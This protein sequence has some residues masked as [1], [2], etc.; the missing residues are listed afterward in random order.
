MLKSRSR[1]LVAATFAKRSI[2]G[3][4]PMEDFVELSDA[5]DN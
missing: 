4:D 3:I 5:K 1:E 2:F